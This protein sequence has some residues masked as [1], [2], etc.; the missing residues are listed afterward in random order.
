[1]ESRIDSLVELG[2]L[3]LI[4]FFVLRWCGAFG[5]KWFDKFWGVQDRQARAITKLASH[6]EKSLG[7]QEETLTVMR[8]IARQNAH[9]DAARGFGGNV[10]LDEH[11]IP[12]ASSRASSMSAWTSA[13]GAA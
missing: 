4:L 13:G 10:L 3:A 11:G 7:S 8:A 2:A 6:V 9:P 12:A 1:M 5:T